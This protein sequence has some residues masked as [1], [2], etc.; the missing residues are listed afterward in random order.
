MIIRKIAFVF[1]F[2]NFMSFAYSQ[3]YNAIDSIV[4]KYPNF[5]NTEKLAERIQK[6]FTTEYDKARAIYSWVALNIDYDVKK[7][8]NPSNPKTFNSKDKSEVD[9]QMKNY[10]DNEIKKAFRNKKGVCEDFSLLYEQIGT[11]LGLKVK[12]IIG[13]AKVDLID[14]GRKRLYSNHAWNTVEI[15]GKS[16]MIDA[17]WGGG[18]LDYKTET[19]V[20]KFTPI[21]FDMEPKYFYAKHFPE[22]EFKN[23][24]IDKEAYLNGPLIY[25][26]MIEKD[27]EVFLPKSGIV[28]VNV[29]D[30]ILFKIKNL[31]EFNELACFD[32]DDEKLEML[33]LKEENNALEFEI[34]CQK[35]MRQ[36]ITFYRNQKAL[37]SFKIITK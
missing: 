35:K 15:D 32:N 24:K 20:K 5:G 28:N 8:R 19:A 13:D 1:V 26:A 36:F 31:S 2:F 17:T 34:L 27:C 6:D 7:F 21:Y 25:D 4:S 9:R 12:V 37:A 14:I 30:K 16:I 10:R 33:I 11:L 3:K 23:P 29:G 18:Y 22:S